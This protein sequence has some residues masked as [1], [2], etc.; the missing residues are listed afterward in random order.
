MFNENS[1]KCHLVQN[2][3]AIGFNMADKSASTVAVMNS[4]S[5]TPR[6]YLP[7]APELA[8]ISF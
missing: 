8:L 5:L 4:K 6:N 7:F 2:G 3:K 1:D